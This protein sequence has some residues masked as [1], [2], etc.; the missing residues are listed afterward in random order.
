MPVSAPQPTQKG[1]EFNDQHK[2]GRF[3]QYLFR[4]SGNAEMAYDIASRRGDSPVVGMFGAQVGPAGAKAMG[5]D[6]IS[7]GGALITPYVARDVIPILESEA[8]FLDGVTEVPFESGSYSQAYG[9]TGPTVTW[10][11]ESENISDTTITTGQ[12]QMSAKKAAM[13]IAVSNELLQDSSGAGAALVQQ[14]MARKMGAELDAKF[15]RSDGTANTPTGIK[16]LIT[17]AGNSAAITTPDSVASINTDM[18]KCVGFPEDDKVP[19]AN[20]AWFMAAR[21]RRALSK[22][23]TS[24]STPV[25]PQVLEGKFLDAP[26]RVSHEIPTNLSGSNSEVYYSNQ[27]HILYGRQM[28]GFEVHVAPYAAYYNSAAG[29]VLSGLSRQETAFLMVVRVD[30][31]DSYRGKSGGLLTGVTWT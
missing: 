19:S 28:S 2:F 21:T 11:G 9:D 6:L 14:T 20:P 1:P 23:L 5:E 12:L 18:H 7:T 10:G 31:S 25:W 3:A 16:T 8:V 13:V 4:A 29:G 26:I 27:G 22:Q 24:T 30:I 17:S 15:L